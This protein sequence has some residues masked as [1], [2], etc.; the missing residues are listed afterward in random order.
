MD[1]AGHGLRRPGF[2]LLA[3]GLLAADLWTKSWAHAYAATGEQPVFGAWFSIQKVFN[4]GGV[5]GL[6][7]SMTLPLTLLRAAA[8]IFILWLVARQPR[9]NR[10]G[11]FTLAL[12]LA[13]A[14][15]NLYDNLS[16]WAPWPGNGHVRDFLKV[17]LGAAPSFWP[18]RLWP[19][20]P[21]PIF[22]LADACI[23]VGFLLLLTGLARVRIRGHAPGSSPAEERRS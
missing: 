11:V 13:G 12:L 17:D 16:A 10:L 7:Q 6:G 3:L 22:N 5:F 8:V 19:F 1:R 18:E 23:V 14:A 9:D 21:W 15:G 4:P 2:W 20:H